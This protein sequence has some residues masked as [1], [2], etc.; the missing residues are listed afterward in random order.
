MPLPLL[1]YAPTSQNSRVAGYD[2]GGDEQAKLFSTENILSPSDMGALIEAAY[3]QIFFHAFKCDR[4]SVLESQLRNGQITVREFIRGLLL[5]N[6]YRNSF[7]NLNSNYRV[8][9]HTVEKV[10]GRNV[11]GEQE[12]ISWSAVL[13]TKGL[14]GFVDDLLNS[15]EYLTAFGDDIVPYHRRRVLA[16]RDT[17]ERPFNIKSPRYDA[18]Y[19]KVFGFPKAVFMGGPIPRKMRSDTITR[20]GDPASFLDLARSIP[21]RYQAASGITASSLGSYLNKVPVRR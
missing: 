14:A 10:L 8:V 2:I 17:G 19:R 12:K 15:D 13:M 11:Y 5:S 18:Y 9:Q 1:N 3:R 16:G 20:A 21:I 6:T 7:Y 4:E